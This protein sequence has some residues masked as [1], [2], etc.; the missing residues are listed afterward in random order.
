VLGTDD[1]DGD[2]NGNGI[3]G[4]QHIAITHSFPGGPPGLSARVR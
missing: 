4:A 3:V 1:P 2:L